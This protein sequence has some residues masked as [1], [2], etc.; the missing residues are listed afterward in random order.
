MIDAGQPSA[1]EG[2]AQE[3]QRAF[4]AFNQVSQALTMAYQG[5]QGRVE[6][7]TAELA[8]ANG[9]LRR[10]HD[11]KEALAERL[12]LL[13]N[14]LPAGVI[15]LDGDARVSEANPAARR[16]LGHEIVGE[17]W[18]A[19]LRSLLVATE[20]PAEWQSSG[21]CRVAIVESPIDSTG[22]R[23][24]LVHDVT[25]AH[26]LKAELERNQ[27]LVAMGE[28]AASLAHQLR[29]PL[30]TALLYSANLCQPELADAARI[31]FAEKT[32]AQLRRLERLIREVLLF[33][34]G[35]RAGSD[36]MLVGQLLADAAQTVQP[37]FREKSVAYR[38]DCEAAQEQLNGSRKAL[39]G[40]L[41]NLLENALQACSAGGEVRLTAR[42]ADG[43]LRI[44][45]RD[46]GQGIT[47]E[48]QARVFE[49]FF[50][51][52]AHGTGLGLAIALAVARAHGGSIRLSSAPDQ[53]S[54]FVL[55]LPIE[56]TTLQEE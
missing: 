17:L 13:L 24:I 48:V 6:S 9:E 46:T 31:R 22:G 18:P 54:E 30:A 2:R 11:A 55:V 7:L 44:G 12:R 52:R 27:R 10:Q 14:A 42:A 4:D 53:G 36:R 56:T 34:R 51:T 16:I 35:E 8:T 5:L 20:T 23:I 21:R 25:A 50:T 15:V 19:L 1:Q 41:V 26:S 33:A 37:L 28:M 3:L 47:S 29:T 49:P 43:Q 39:A 38:V 40:A 45:V 32:T